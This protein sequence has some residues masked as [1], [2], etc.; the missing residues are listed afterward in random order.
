VGF[1]EAPERTLAF[2]VQGGEV[3]TV[4]AGATIAGRFRVQ[5]VTEEAVLLSSMA[6]DRQVRL[7]LTAEAAPAPKR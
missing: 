3:H 6:G 1:L 7:P 5:T 4:E 2:I